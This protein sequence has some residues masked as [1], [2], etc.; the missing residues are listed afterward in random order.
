MRTRSCFSF[1]AVLLLSA[2]ACGD[3][4]DDGQSATV[5]D[6]ARESG[7][8]D[9]LVGALEATGLDVT[10]SGQGPYTVFAPTDAAFERLPAGV[11]E[12]LDADTLEQILTYHVVAGEVPASAVVELDAAATV[13]G[14]EVTIRVIDG[15]VV[16]D[17]VVQVAQTDMQADNGIIHVID[18]VLLPPAIGFPGDLVEAVSAYP[19][20][21]PLVGAVADAGLVE[22]LQDDNDGDGFTLLA[23]TRFAFDAVDVSALTSDQLADVLL[24]HAISGTLDASAISGLTE[25]ETL[26]GGL[27]EIAVDDDGVL[28]DDSTRVIRTDLET[29][30]GI[31]HV[32]DSVLQPPGL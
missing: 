16:L 7:D 3:D 26:E 30:N 29:D 19:I 24:Y 13:E 27:V 8:F 25:A 32:L 12:G 5:V 20:F 31:I 28:L 6:V 21:D 14:S 17:G 10:L 18:A 23:P 11:L 9:I 22:A 2:A 15:T 1:A 4:D